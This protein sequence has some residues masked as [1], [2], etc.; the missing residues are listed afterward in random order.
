MKETS[1]SEKTRVWWRSE[2]DARGTWT[3]PALPEIAFRSSSWD[4]SKHPTSLQTSV[5]RWLW[6][7]ATIPAPLAPCPHRLSLHHPAASTNP[8]SMS[9]CP[10]AT[11]WPFSS[12][13]PSTRWC[14]CAPAATTVAA[15][16]VGNAGIPP[17]STWWTWPPPTWCTVY[18][19]L[20]W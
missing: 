9:S 12:A 5:W 10:S 7:R 18:R 3:N 16:A 14:C 2:D 11:R 13:S 17:W 4:W 20:S 15:V 8:T 19:C 6:Q 1:V